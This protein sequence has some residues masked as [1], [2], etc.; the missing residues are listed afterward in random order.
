[1]NLKVLARI[2]VTVALLAWLFF[3]INFHE[4]GQVIRTAH[5][6]WLLLGVA[7]YVGGMLAATW[8]WQ[9]LLSGM[10]IPQPFARL[11][12]LFFVG[13]FF[14]MFLPSYVGGDMMKMVMLAPTVEKRAVA[15]SSV[16]MDRV[17]GLAVVLAI[18]LLAALALPIV[19]TN[20]QVIT[21]LAITA[22]AFIVGLTALV[23]R[24]VLTLGLRLLPGF[25]RTRLA[26][27]LLRVHE[28]LISLRHQP[29]AILGALGTSVLLQ[30]AVSLSIYCA[31]RALNVGAPPIAYFA[32][33]PIA[34]AIIVL[35]ISIN[36]LGVQDQVL[37]AML[38]IVG[39]LPAQA[40][41]LSLYLHV[42]RNGVGIA[43]GLVFAATR[44]RE[45]AS[46]AAPAQR[47]R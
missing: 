21:A 2:A 37:V 43:G 31:G 1:M 20:P 29:L 45:P 44:S 32:L 14:S 28:T 7:I 19:R 24:P 23:S 18:G 47:Q 36:G 5:P 25:L 9:I 41:V 6:G 38:G 35:P 40:A 33:I 39:V 22:L 12:R 13:C 17:I 3:T 46:D 30:S 11:T 42:L 10:G 8:R 34:S 15:I 4:M 27:P 16:L 26:E